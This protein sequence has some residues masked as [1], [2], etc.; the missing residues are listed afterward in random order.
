MSAIV[1]LDTETTGLHPHTRRPWEIAMIRREPG[2]EDDRLLIQIVDVDLSH[3]DKNAL[4]VGRFR[5]RHHSFVAGSFGYLLESDAARQVDAFTADAQ[6]A[7]VNINFDEVTLDA[8]LRR[9]GLMPRWDYHLID[10]PSMAL[11]YLHGR[12][13]ESGL[14]EFREAAALPYKSYELSADAWEW[15]FT[16]FDYH[17][18]KSLHAI[19]FGIAQYREAKQTAA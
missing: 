6:L 16:D 11:G 4:A 13:E 18:L 8:M 17:Y 5:E 14:S 1:F 10:L 7:G 19:V 2:C 3:A 12:A 15:D 9:H